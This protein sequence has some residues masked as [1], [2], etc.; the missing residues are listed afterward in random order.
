MDEA[1]IELKRMVLKMECL[2][3]ACD[4]ND[5]GT[6]IASGEFPRSEEIIKIAINYYKF[7]TINF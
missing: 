2:R 7:L 3:L 5:I 6:T 4:S 1:E